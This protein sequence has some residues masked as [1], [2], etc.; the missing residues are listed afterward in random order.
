MSGAPR[1]WRREADEATALARDAKGRAAVTLLELDTVQREVE[2]EVEEYADFAPGDGPRLTSRWAPLRDE[3]FAVTSGY[4]DV[5]QR[6]DLETDLGMEQARTAAAEF[7]MVGAAMSDVAR[8]VTAFG[9]AAE[10][11]FT[12]VRRQVAEL[13]VAMRELDPTVTAA[14]RA[15]ADAR[16]AGLLTVDPDV[17]LTAAEAA[18]ARAHEGDAV[19]GL[20]ATQEAA[21]LATAH[22]RAAL[23]LARQLPARREE[24][25][26]RAS[27]TRTRVQVTT[28]RV[29]SL[30]AT[31][32]EL[33]KRYAAA[34]SVDLAR[35]P[36]DVAAHLRRAQQALTTA[37]ELSGPDAQRWAEAEAALRAARAAC[38][39]AEDAA[40]VVLRRLAELD[41]IAKDP[42][43]LLATTRRTVRDAQRFLLDSA[44][45]LDTRL[46][47]V[48]DRLAERLD[49]ASH[50]LARRDPAVRT[51]HWAYLSELTDIAA[52]AGAVV[53]EVR[54]RRRAS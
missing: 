51:D 18:A 34:A 12:Q 23:E 36:A 52:R 5:E 37:D 21:R 49:A 7:A 19:H 6:Y 45:T 35:A 40:Q 48:L 14:R 30:P 25:A 26:R 27:S 1:W 28:N 43:P 3:A 32:S 24:V 11:K 53:T 33:R 50:E 9:E 16:A 47:G 2:R 42:Q 46:A 20:R 31:L 54:E 22:A 41:S 17:E 38:T 13:T 29:A 8:R 44:P 4:L 15:V 39:E 10:P